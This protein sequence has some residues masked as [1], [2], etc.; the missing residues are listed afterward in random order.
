[1]RY[2][3][4]KHAPSLYP[5]NLEERA[6]V[7]QW[8]DFSADPISLAASKVMHNTYFYRLTNTAKDERSLQDGFLWLD[9]YLPIL[10]RQLT[11]HHY[12]AGNQLTIADFSLL[13]ALDVAE[14]IQLNLA[15]FS[16]L[17]TW[18]QQLMKEA[19][20]Q[21]C[22][23]SYAASFKQCVGALFDDVKV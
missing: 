15:A 22:H 23:S 14:L 19:F 7:E 2:L 9:R 1:M 3:T 10:E 13:A 5:K 8:L 16:H 6:I 18:R 21:D 11:K 17:N 4:D 20:Y 12:I